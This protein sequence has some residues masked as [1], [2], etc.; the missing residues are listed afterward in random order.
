MPQSPEDTARILRRAT[1]ETNAELGIRA[2][3]VRTI[4]AR[5]TFTESVE[6]WQELL[7]QLDVVNGAQGN[8]VVDGFQAKLRAVL[9]PPKET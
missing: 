4:P 6:Y 3:I 5:L 9:N 1:S 2:P 8:Y 7:A